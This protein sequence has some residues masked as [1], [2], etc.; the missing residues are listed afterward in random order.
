MQP[1][2]HTLIILLL[3]VGLLNSR[4]LKGMW[5]PVVALILALSLVAPVLPISL[6]WPWL[7]GLTLPLLFWQT[8]Q[9]LINARLLSE[10]RKIDFL[11]WSLVTLNLSLA[12]W[13]FGN[14]SFW[15]ALLFSLLIAS[16]VWRA[17]E[18]EQQPSYLGQIGPLMLAYLLAE[19]APAVEAP[20]RYHLALAGGVVVGLVVGVA[21]VN[22]SERVP[23]GWKRDLFSV[24]QG[25]LAYLAGLLLGFS[26]VAASITSIV[27]YAAIGSR[28][29]LWATGIVQPRPLDSRPVFAVA[30]ALLAFV[31]WQTHIPLTPVLLFDFLIGLVIVALAMWVGRLLNC[32]AFREDRSLGKVVARAGLLLAPALLL[33][34]RA[35]LLEPEPLAIAFIAALAT[36]YGAH[37][38][39]TPLLNIYRSI[40]EAR[41]ETRESNLL[42]N[43]LRVNELMT[44]DF[45]TVS[46]ETPVGNVIPL[47]LG[48][49]KACIPVVDDEQKFLGI[50]TEA[51]LFL[52]E[53]HIPR[54]MVTYTAL[55]GERVFP[56]ELAEAYAELS[57]E[58]TVADVMTEPKLWLSE[59]DLVSKAVQWMV[60]LNVNCLP[61]LT[62][63]P[64]SGGK[65]VGLLTRSQ[66]VRHLHQDRS[67]EMLTNRW[68]NE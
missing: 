2:E 17:A 16:I 27:V 15:A 35:L 11:L 23:A 9:R 21:S 14:I 7:T 40:D 67:R 60:S 61:V 45:Q 64:K 54:S 39:L 41:V 3:L 10:T 56:E 18:D 52:K 43:R 46:P 1:L 37:I 8:A 36:T 62:G 5:W 34:P 63:D 42:L 66:I 24:G 22:I 68:P 50:I 32:Y 6:P 57:D 38:G 12:L 26:G 31:T 33:W 29:G 65:L 4:V 28:R 51:D 55:F 20:N 19:I 30:V 13:L 58:L 25:Y 48:D 49:G 47:L 59:D 44:T 53:K